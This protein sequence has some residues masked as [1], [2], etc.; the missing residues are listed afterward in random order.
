[1]T[2]VHADLATL[3][4]YRQGELDEAREAAL[5]EHYL[6]CALC[7]AQ[8]AVVQAIA[9]GV[10]GAFAMG[11][12]GTVITPAFAERLRSQGLRMREY[13]VP[14]NG[15]VNC[16]VAPED[17]VLLSRLQ[18]S[19]EGVERLDAIVTYEG[20]ERLE[21][22]PFDAASGEVVVAHGIEWVRT[23]PEHRRSVRLVAVGPAGD[24]VLGEY[25]FN[26]SPHR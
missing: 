10:R 20:E 17:E 8:L 6:G 14:R 24:R 1:M 5:E 18:L 15:S 19:L 7:S 21:D 25:T 26:H 12:I 11:R 9:A 4:A 3:L 16:S 23:L 2:G 22:V 13:R